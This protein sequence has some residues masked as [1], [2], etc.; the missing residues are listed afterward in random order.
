[1]DI[2]I[3]IPAWN[4][5]KTIC[6]VASIAIAAK[7]GPV[8]VVSDGSSDNTVA[9]AK[10]SGAM[11]LDLQ[12]NQGKGGAV[13]AGVAQLATEWVLLLDADLTNLQ[14]QHLHQLCAPVLQNTALQNTADTTLGIFNGGRGATDLALKLTPALSG[15]R[16]IRRQVLLD[17]PDLAST[18]YGIEIAITEAIK[19]KGLRLQIVTW[20]GV[21]QLMKEEKR[22]L[23]LGFAYRLKMYWQILEAMLKKKKVV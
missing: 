18:R 13:A 22:G 6:E 2:A 19:A 15:Q 21:S 3:L 11:V 7:L 16:V 5:E 17:I 9:E 10:K 4:E 1:M 23:L 14:P 12:P 20:Q 8:L